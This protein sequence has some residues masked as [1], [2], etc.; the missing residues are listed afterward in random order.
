MKSIFVTI[1]LSLHSPTG[2]PFYVRTLEILAITVPQ[3]NRSG[4]G[5]GANILVHDTWFS[6]RETPNEIMRAIDND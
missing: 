3:P 5:I 6:V 2:A 1:F 4:P